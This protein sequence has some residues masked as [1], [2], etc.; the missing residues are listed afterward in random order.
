MLAKSKGGLHVAIIM[1]GNGRWAER[2]GL[3]RAAGHRAG[4]AAAR[5]VVEHAVGTDIDRLTLYAF[6]SDRLGRESSRH[7]PRKREMWTCWSA[8]EG[9]RGCPTSCCGSQ[10][11]FTDRMWPDF[12]ESD[13]DEALREFCHR[14]RRYGGLPVP[15]NDPVDAA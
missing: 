14:Q 8:Q 11:L 6:S 13:L 1:D 3:L 4:V 15:A 5:R 7:Y 2:R 9:R 12:G 10:L